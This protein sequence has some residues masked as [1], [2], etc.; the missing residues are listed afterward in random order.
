MYDILATMGK[1]SQGDFAARLDVISGDEFEEIAVRLNSLI[2][3]MESTVQRLMERIELAKTA[4]MKQLQ[5][6]FDPHFLY[7]T[8]DTAKWM[9]KMGETEKA[10]LVLTNMA[11]VLRYSVHDRRSESMVALREDIVAIKTYLEIHKLSLGERLTVDY[12]IDESVLSCRV[13]K[14][15]VQPIV[16]NALV[17]GIGATGSGRLGLS[18]RGSGGDVVI[19]VTDTGEGFA[20]DP[21]QIARA[22]ATEGG[23]E[24]SMGMS[25]VLRRARLH[26]GERFSFDIKSGKG[27]GSVVT[28]T[29]PREA[30]GAPCTE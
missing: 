1:V 10:S 21:A 23:T 13:P 26:Y 6:Q 28:L 5:A 17:H 30:E 18:I 27:S 19:E 25:L 22:A 2:V 24:S 16:E 9:M 7:N 4:E 15:L 3:E 20:V 29:I 11:K 12:D 8:I 14:L